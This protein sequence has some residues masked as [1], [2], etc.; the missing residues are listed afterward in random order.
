ME[1]PIRVLVASGPRLLR[2]LILNM[3]LDQPDIEVADHVPEGADILETV[4]K[5]NPDFVVIAQDKMAER[6][7]ICDTLLTERPDIRIITVARHD[8]YLVYYWASPDIHSRR[9]EASEDA[10][11]GILRTKPTRGVA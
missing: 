6:P 7:N 4:E 11:L 10:L 8:N 2:D 3:F 5:T 9:V 1:T